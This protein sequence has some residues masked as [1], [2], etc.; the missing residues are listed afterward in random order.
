LF[1]EGIEQFNVAMPTFQ[2]VSGLHFP[3]AFR[4]VTLLALMTWISTLCNSGIR[5][6]FDPNARFA[7][8]SYLYATM[9]GS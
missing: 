9:D 7:A 2:S 5:V 1:F 3:D 4:Y 6:P 8:H